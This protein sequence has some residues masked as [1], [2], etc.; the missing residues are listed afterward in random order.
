MP[1]GG[2]FAHIWK[3]LRRLSSTVRVYKNDA[4]LTG[5]LSGLAERM[6]RLAEK[7]AAKD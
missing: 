3:T 7:L 2:L 1:Y 4:A 5:A 6:E